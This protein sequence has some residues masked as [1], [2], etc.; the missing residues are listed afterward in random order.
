M[1]DAHLQSARSRLRA[2]RRRPRRKPTPRHAARFPRDDGRIC[3][4]FVPRQSGRPSRCKSPTV[5]RSAEPPPRAGRSGPGDR[6]RVRVRQAIRAPVRRWPPVPPSPVHK[7]G[8]HHHW[9]RAPAPGLQPRPGNVRPWPSVRRGRNGGRAAPFP[10]AGRYPR[11]TGAPAPC[12]SM[13]ARP[14]AD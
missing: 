2:A 14:C 7:A 3:A 4:G 13:H 10:R 5:R 9:H 12:R 6:R 11:R 8:W 1:K